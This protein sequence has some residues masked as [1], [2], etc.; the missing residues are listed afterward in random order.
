MIK[1]VTYYLCISSQFM[2]RKREACTLLLLIQDPLCKCVGVSFLC[3]S[4]L[5][6]QRLQKASFDVI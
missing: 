3:T 4:F 5:L 6:T 1:A 2:Q